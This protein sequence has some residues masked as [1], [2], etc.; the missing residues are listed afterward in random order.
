MIAQHSAFCRLPGREW[1]WAMTVFEAASQ[2]AAMAPSKETST[3]RALIRLQSC[4][5]RTTPC[6][7]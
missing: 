5:V 2:L 4:W 3:P 6:S 7:Q 1:S